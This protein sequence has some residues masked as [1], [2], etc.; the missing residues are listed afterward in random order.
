M[1]IKWILKERDNE[2]VDWFHSTQHDVQCRPLVKLLVPLEV[3]M[4]DFEAS[5]V[6]CASAV[7][8]KRVK[9]SYKRNK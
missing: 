7:Y 6:G 1:I 8:L 5:Q 4:T 2:C 9:I 3:D